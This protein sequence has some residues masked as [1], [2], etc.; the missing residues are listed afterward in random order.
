[1]D[2]RIHKA[3]AQVQARAVYLLLPA[4]LPHARNDTRLHSHVRLFH[5]FCKYVHHMRIFE[6]E[7]RLFPSGRRLDDA[8]FHCANHLSCPATSFARRARHLLRLPHGPAMVLQ[9]V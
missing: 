2:M 5:L 4:V 1:M 7:L 3:G 9:P 8:F 6:Y